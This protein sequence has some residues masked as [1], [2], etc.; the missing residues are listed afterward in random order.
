MEAAMLTFEIRVLS[1]V[2]AIAAAASVSLAG[3]AETLTL[4][5][6]G[7]DRTA[8]VYVP[9]STVGSPAPLVIALHSAGSTGKGFRGRA[10]LDVVADREKFVMV[11]PDAI[12]NVW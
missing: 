3:A 5:H 10:G 12:A 8:V 11:Y 4:Q 7:I 2:C 1:L 6:Q 9:A